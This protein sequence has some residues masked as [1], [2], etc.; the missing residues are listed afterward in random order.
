MKKEEF[1]FLDGFLTEPLWDRQKLAE[2]LKTTPETIAVW[3]CTK[4]YDLKPIKVG[5]SVRY[6]PVYIRHFYAEKYLK[7]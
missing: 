5:T 6:C 7:P 3:D 4:R 1:N 2:L